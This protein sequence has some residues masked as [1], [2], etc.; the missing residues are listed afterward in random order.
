MC[1]YY[2]VYSI[3]VFMYVYAYI[4]AIQLSESNFFYLCACGLGV[5]GQQIGERFPHNQL[6][7]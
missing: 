2:S 6:V 5:T 7:L 1:V 3:Y 4:Y